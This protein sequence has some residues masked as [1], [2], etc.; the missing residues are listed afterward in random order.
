MRTLVSALL[1]L[2]LIGCGGD[3]EGSSGMSGQGAGT[4]GAG[5]GGAG[6]G[7]SGGSSG[8]AGM[9]TG[10]MGGGAGGSSGSA[11]EGGAGG[12]G[13][14]GGMPV[15]V[16]LAQ[17]PAQFAGAICDA[18]EACVGPRKLSD[19]TRGEACDA[20][21]TAE[22][23]AGELAYIDA[24]ITGGRVLYNPEQLEGCLQG[25]RAMGCAVA[26]DTYPEACVQV[27]A[28][29]VPQGGA[30]TISSECEGTAFCAGRNACPSTCQPLLSAGAACLSDDECG[31]GLVCA[32]G[33]C[34]A[35]AGEGAACG[36]NTGVTCA[37]GLGCINFTETTPGV[38]TPNA[39]ILSGDVDGACSPAGTLCKEGLSCVP[40]SA[41]PEAWRCKAGVAA[42]EACML[43]LP[44]QCPNGYYCDAAGF[45]VEG[46]CVALPEDGAPCVLTQLL[47]APGFA[48][49]VEGSNP[50]CR[51][52]KPNG[53]AC[54]GDAACRS[55]RCSGGACAPPVVC[56]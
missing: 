9:A 17:V 14:G 33:E 37:L 4:G 30:C 51:A 10:G 18:L 7:A 28:G 8:A 36:G 11:G 29:N 41:A 25:I 49:V 31:D 12:E 5:A 1:V 55:G 16:P 50:V 21:L 52:I 24:S 42:G 46:T 6:A 15:I 47:C 48:C 13:G 35:L 45:F 44:G 2:G 34:L 38:C 40:V 39:E 20:R 32:G 22:L 19:L 54:S 56:Q 43:A 53:E 27:I 3:D 26:T 23:E